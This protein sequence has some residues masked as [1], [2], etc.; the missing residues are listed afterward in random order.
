MIIMIILIE[1]LEFLIK[2]ENLPVALFN[3]TV[4]NF[5]LICFPIFHRFYRDA[6]MKTDD[7]VLMPF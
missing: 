7:T 5:V 6:F 3:K 4:F 1:M 2:N